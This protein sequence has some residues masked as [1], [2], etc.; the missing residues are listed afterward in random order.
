VGGRGRGGRAVSLEVSPLE[1]RPSSTQGRPAPRAGAVQGG[2]AVAWEGH[3]PPPS[4]APTR[5]VVR[6]SRAPALRWRSPPFFQ[7]ARP[8][9]LAGAPLLQFQGRGRGSSNHIDHGFY[10]LQ[11]KHPLKQVG[12]HDRIGHVVV[13]SN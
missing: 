12:K 8:W 2:G 5:L 13:T 6:C 1:P 11:N 3:G 7:V 9:P 4:C 10:V